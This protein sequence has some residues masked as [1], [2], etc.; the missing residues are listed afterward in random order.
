MERDSYAPGTPSWVDLG[1]PD[2]DASVAFYSALLG[3]EVAEAH[4][5]AGGYRLAFLRGKSVAGIGPQQGPVPAWTTYFA[6]DD[7]DVTA[8]AIKDNG[9]TVMMEPIDVMGQGRMAIA[10]DTEGAAF[11]LWQAQ[12]HTGAQLVNETGTFGWNEL[13]TRAMGQAK[14]FYP[15][16]FGFTFDDET[17]GAGYTLWLVN[18]QMVAGALP[19]PEGMPPRVPAHW[20][21]F[22]VVDDTDKAVAT[23]TDLGGMVVKEPFD[24]PNV[25]RIAMVHGPAHES[26]GLFSSGNQT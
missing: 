17:M 22:F 25:G 12:V 18:G 21:V 5:D 1:S 7:A 19:M 4:P 13:W 24:V 3:W 14:L 15:A 10:M 8:A 9:G 20:A 11:G 23:V 16:V 26:F 2:I 6:T